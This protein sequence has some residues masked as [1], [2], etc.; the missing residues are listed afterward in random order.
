MPLGAKWEFAARGGIV[1]QGNFAFSGSDAADEVAWHEWNSGS[2]THEVGLLMPNALGL[3]DMSG[4]VWE[5]VWDWFGTYP[6]F[7]ETDPTGP[8]AGVFRVVRGG[9]WL[10]TP[11][12]VR[13]AHRSVTYPDDRS[14][15]LGFRL[16]RP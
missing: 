10:F 14:I 3:Y 1:C 12:F 11:A 13:S 15:D 2:R 16:V 9:G 7:V 8:A 5:W 6:D 4:N